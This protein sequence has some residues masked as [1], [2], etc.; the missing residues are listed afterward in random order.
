MGVCGGEIFFYHG[1]RCG[2]MDL[3]TKMAL[4]D[5]KNDDGERKHIRERANVQKSHRCRGRPKTSDEI[6]VTDDVDANDEVITKSEDVVE[7]VSMFPCQ[8]FDY[9]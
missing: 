9:S 8:C 2:E 6:G 5:E 4:V 7:V 1:V 3:W